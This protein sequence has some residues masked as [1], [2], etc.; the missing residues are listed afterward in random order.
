M[1]NNI[2]VDPFLGLVFVQGVHIYNF[3]C[4]FIHHFKGTQMQI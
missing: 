4:L 1:E 2:H 3:F